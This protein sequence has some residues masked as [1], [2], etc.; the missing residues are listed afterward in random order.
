MSCIRNSIKPA[1][2]IG[3]FCIHVLAEILE[4]V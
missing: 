4:I 1:L 2:D 3:L